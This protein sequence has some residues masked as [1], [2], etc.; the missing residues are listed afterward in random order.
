MKKFILLSVVGVMF[1]GLAQ[2]CDKNDN[3]DVYE[4]KSIEKDEIKEGDI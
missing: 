4:I 1:I 2:S 3:D